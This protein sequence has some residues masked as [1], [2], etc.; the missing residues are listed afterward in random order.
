MIAADVHALDR[1][2][3]GVRAFRQMDDKGVYLGGVIRSISFR[4]SFSLARFTEG[5]GIVIDLNI[6]VGFFS[7]KRF[8]VCVC[9]SQAVADRLIQLRSN[10]V[11]LAIRRFFDL[12]NKGILSPGIRHIGR[13]APSRGVLIF[14]GRGKAAGGVFMKVPFTV[15][16]RN[17]L[18]GCVFLTVYRDG[19]I[20]MHL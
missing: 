1:G 4:V 19:G 17:I 20:V 5:I 3:T 8:V 11:V 13:K 15:G 2:S 14:T 16:R 7:R 18:S 12:V 9:K 6:N 10:T